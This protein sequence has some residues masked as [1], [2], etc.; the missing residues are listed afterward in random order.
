MKQ[1][2]HM[3]TLIWHQQARSHWHLH[4]SS[5]T[6]SR[7]VTEYLQR[8]AAA[9][10]QSPSSHGFAGPSPTEQL[11]S[12]CRSVAK[13][14]PAPCDP[15]DCSTQGSSVLHYLPE[16]VHSCPQSQGCYLTITSSAA[17][18][19]FVFNLS[20]HQGPFQWGGS[21]HQISSLLKTFLLAF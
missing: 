21:S 3:R 9:V 17:P 20:R 15:T 19:P 8:K 12:C 7:N 16:P 1:P 6:P 2:H 14:C 10:L 5:S 4:L 13:S 11:P 18:S